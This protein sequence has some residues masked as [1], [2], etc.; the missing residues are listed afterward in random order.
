M[1]LVQTAERLALKYLPT[2]VTT[3]LQ[4]LKQRLPLRLLQSHPIVQMYINDA[5]TR[6][7]VGMHNFYS[8]LLSEVESP[9]SAH[10]RFYSPSGELV[11]KQSLSI[12]HF[13]AR[14]VDVKQVLE[15]RHAKAPYGI[16]TVQITPWLARRRVYRDYG[17]F[18]AHF[19]MFFRDE[20]AGAVEQTHPLS[21]TDPNN[22]P[23]GTFVSSQV[24]STAKLRQL[25][26]YQYNPSAR[27]H[28]LEHSLVHLATGA[29]V[30]TSSVT[31]R[32]MGSA[33]T[34][35]TMDELGHVPPQLSFCV[36][37]LPSGNA[38][39]MLRRV[40]HGGSHSMSHA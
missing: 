8:T 34:V 19:F 6:S 4:A 7:Y 33:C 11:A 15:G 29:K 35:F 21:T 2:N 36:D 31:I 26:V 30:A 17:Q 9:A 22:A 20:Q 39:P 3:R 40:F 28:T 1:S 37:A 10:L 24:I 14:A 25:V 27:P 23:S 5:Y 32:P 12:P 18:S 13:A 38:K 16:V